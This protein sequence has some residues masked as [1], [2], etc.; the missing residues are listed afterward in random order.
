MPGLL[1]M[2]GWIATHQT[3]KLI[4]WYKWTFDE[5]VGE[6]PGDARLVGYA[7]ADSL[8]VFPVIVQGVQPTPE[9]HQRAL[10]MVLL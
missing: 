4:A 7:G 3:L 10:G 8:R 1:G 5:R 2:R 6:I 9:D